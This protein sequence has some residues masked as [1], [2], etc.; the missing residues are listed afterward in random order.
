MNEKVPLSALTYQIWHYH[1]SFS[2][3]LQSMNYVETFLYFYCFFESN[4]DIVVKN[5]ADFWGEI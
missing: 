3:V 5:K 2:V 4:A 1:F